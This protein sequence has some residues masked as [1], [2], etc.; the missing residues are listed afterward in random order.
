MIHSSNFAK[1][2]S[3]I[4]DQR[5]RPI[6]ESWLKLYLLITNSAGVIFTTSMCNYFFTLRYFHSP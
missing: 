6:F 2:E 4:Q 5:R 1:S 3:T